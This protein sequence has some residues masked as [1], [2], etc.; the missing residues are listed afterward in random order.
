MK[1]KPPNRVFPADVKDSVKDWI[2]QKQKH[3]SVNPI[4]QLED[5]LNDNQYVTGSYSSLSSHSGSN[6]FEPLENILSSDSTS[7]LSSPI[8]PTNIKTTCNQFK[9]APIF[10]QFNDSLA[11]Q[12]ISETN[13][14]RN[15]LVTDTMFLNNETTTTSPV[16]TNEIKEE[17]KDSHL[18][19]FLHPHMESVDLANDKDEFQKTTNSKPMRKRLTSNQKQAHNKIEKRYR[20]NINTKIAKLQQIIPWVACE[21]PAFEVGGSLKREQEF[22]KNSATR[23]NKSMILEK[24]VDYIL[25]L[26]N[27]ESLHQ[28]EVQR[29]RNEVD[30]LKSKSM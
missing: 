10:D 11:M 22:K 19:V 24:A 17:P 5:D 18:N 21:K 15:F 16:F 12:N 20:I 25:Y 28:L 4:K 30:S 1:R 26:Q 9:E 7:S 14:N 13:E 2:L 29:L 27:N 23:L 3:F 8:E 6:W